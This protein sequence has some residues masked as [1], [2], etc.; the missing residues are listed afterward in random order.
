MKRS[1]LRKLI[2]E[3]ITTVLKERYID[4]EQRGMALNYS[5]EELE[6]AIKNIKN[7]E[8]WAEKYFRS[9]PGVLDMI[10]RLVTV[11]EKMR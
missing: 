2:K 11:F 4:P 9:L 7:P 6:D 3:E 8:D 10:D 1:D 5:I